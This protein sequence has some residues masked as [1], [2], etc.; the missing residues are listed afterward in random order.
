[1]HRFHGQ[2]RG[3]SQNNPLPADARKVN[4]FAPTVRPLLSS[5]T[6]R[7]PAFDRE[8]CDH[9][10]AQQQGHSRRLRNYFQSE[11]VISG[12]GISLIPVGQPH[13][14]EL[15]IRQDVGARG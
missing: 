10:T 12:A 2:I 9:Q 6:F 7:M 8:E 4:R 15:E 14:I 1:M 3:M 13:G 11:I 5:T